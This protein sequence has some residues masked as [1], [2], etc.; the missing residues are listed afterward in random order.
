PEYRD[1]GLI[2]CRDNGEPWN[3]VTKLRKVFKTAIQASECPPI[4]IHDL[5]H[6]YASLLIAQNASPKYIQH[7]LGHTSIQTTFDVYGHLMPDAG[8]EIVRGLDKFIFGVA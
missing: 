2:F 8:R 6:S 4:R 3:F 1:H 5:R 7:Q